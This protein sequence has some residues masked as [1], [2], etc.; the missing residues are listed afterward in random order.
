MLFGLAGAVAGAIRGLFA[1]P[2]W[3]DSSFLSMRYA[4]RISEDGTVKLLGQDVPIESY[5]DPLWTWL[6]AGLGVLGLDEMRMQ[7]VL[8]G[9]FLS[10]LVGLVAYVAAQK[11]TRFESVVSVPLVLMAPPM[12]LAAHSGGDHLFLTLLSLWVVFSVDRDQERASASWTT[13]IG[14]VLLSMAGLIPL[15]L[16]V[17]LA[18]SF[19]RSDRK[20]L[21]AIVIVT[22][23]MSVFR[24]VVFDSIIPHGAVT[25]AIQGTPDAMIDGFKMM[26]LVFIVGAVGLMG[27]AMRGSRGWTILM[28]GCVWLLWA[29]RGGNGT[30][31][32]GSSLVP[33][34]VFF[35]VGVGSLIDRLP[36]RGLGFVVMIGLVLIDGR[37]AYAENEKAL[38]SRRATI[39]QAQAMAKF[40]RWRFEDDPL[41]VVQTPGMVPYFL[42]KRTLDLQGITH[43]KSTDQQ[44][45]QALS[46]EV[47]VPEGA[48]VSANPARLFVKKNW[49][50]NS[51]KKTHFQHSIMN[52]KD[53]KVIDVHPAW[54]N[55]YF[56][57]ELEKYPPRW[58]KIYAEEE[59]KREQQKQNKPGL[60]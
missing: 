35:G 17:V 50:W 18:A 23:L 20:P 21:M 53:W 54:F 51:L 10:A 60:D 29:W 19:G 43:K 7:P 39:R 9:V 36:H 42:V 25:S 59:R 4:R 28:A 31:S 34:L 47:I 27:L 32:F 33:A 30:E 56:Q 15:V 57:K 24:W 6:M 58:V 1:E 52:T 13:L 8:G 41:I 14:L 44:T 40:L 38:K 2:A 5:F 45:I 48:I 3:L 55:V 49:D 37:T 22:A 46:P 11:F 16:A 12:A 26:P